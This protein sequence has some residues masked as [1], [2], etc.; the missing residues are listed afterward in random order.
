MNHPP[1]QYSDYLKV[2]DLIALQ[3]PK[4]NEY[5]QP[6]H[7]EMLFIVIHQVY[8]LWFKQ[9]IFELDAVIAHFSQPVLDESNML[10][11]CSHLNRIVEIQK[12]LISQV[13]VLE[14]MTPMDFLE[15]RD[16]LYPAS[17]FQSTQFRIIENKMGLSDRITYNGKDYKES[18]C[19]M[20]QS[21]SVKTEGEKSLFQLLENWLERTPFLSEGT[22]DFWDEYRAAVRARIQK[23][24]EVLEQRNISEEAKNS[25][26][27]AL[28]KTAQSFLSLFRED[29]YEELRSKGLWRFSR[30]ALGAALFINLYRHE[31]LLQLPFQLMTHLLDIDENFTQWRNRHAQM[32]HRMLGSKMGT[33]GS[34]GHKYLQ[35]ASDR[36]KVFTDFTNL[37]TF[38]IPKSDLP[39]LP[40][41]LK[42]KIRFQ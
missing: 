8:E 38:F 20:G 40:D 39:E 7:D 4:S 13:D 10:S 31:P 22:Y 37:A 36:H 24:K 9:I 23:Q 33:G 21:Q 5:G 19:P 32:A 18:L 42:K 30:K 2:E 12:I 28:E 15:F 27:K 6:A 3:K 17:G 41:F 35:A 14:T 29:E 25:H 16:F 11:C 34:S 26:L 1:V